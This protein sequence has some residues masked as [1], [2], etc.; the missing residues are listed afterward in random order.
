MA[1][2][3]ASGFLRRRG[4]VLLVALSAL[5]VVACG[6]DEPSEVPDGEQTASATASATATATVTATVDRS[7]LTLTVEVLTA[8]AAAAVPESNVVSWTSTDFGI[9]FDF[10]MGTDPFLLSE[11]PNPEPG[12]VMAWSMI[13][14]SELAATRDAAFGPRG[15]VIEAF[16]FVPGLEPVSAESW[17][18]G[19]VRSNLGMGDGELKATEVGGLPAVRYTWTGSYE[20]M[21]VAVLAEGRLWLFTMLFRDDIGELGAEYGALLASVEFLER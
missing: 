15:L 7:N 9:V 17:V 11:I 2:F 14:E 13:R 19:T 16:E 21:S 18:R 12:L 6:D 10:E 20:G 3:Q 8:T 1:R 4:W 5:T